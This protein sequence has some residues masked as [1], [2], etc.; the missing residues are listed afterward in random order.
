MTSLRLDVWSDLACPWC[1]VG[2][3]RLEAALAGFEHAAEVTVRWRSFEPDPSA[4]RVVDAS[5]SY[6]ERLA[7][8]YRVATAQAQAMIDRMTATAAADGI[9]MRFDRIRPG[10]TFDAHRLLHLAAA[11]GHQ[12]AVKERLL[13]AYLGEGACLGEPATLV[14]LAAEAGLDEADARAVLDGERFAAEV[15][16]DE[17]LAR[18]LGVTGVPFFVLGG[19]LGV[20]GAQP[21]ETLRAALVQAWTAVARDDAGT[22]AAR[23]GATCGPDGCA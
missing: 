1:Y 15:R 16:A 2:T 21:A 22:E 8:K 12:D 23:E 11:C 13:R 14:A 20:S 7:R 18:E 6:A 9:T 10:N 5:S 4:P 17:A 3:R 19:R